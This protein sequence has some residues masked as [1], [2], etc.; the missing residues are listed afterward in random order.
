MAKMAIVSLLETTIIKKIKKA[1]AT[2]RRRRKFEH[3]QMMN[4]RETKRKTA[5][6]QSLTGQNVAKHL[7]CLFDILLLL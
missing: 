2:Q 4:R 6:V 5:N 3:S 1:G 7:F